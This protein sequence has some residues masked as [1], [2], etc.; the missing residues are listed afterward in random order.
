MTSVYAYSVSKTVSRR[1]NRLSYLASHKVNKTKVFIKAVYGNSEDE[2]FRFKLEKYLVS[3]LNPQYFVTQLHDQTVTYFEGLEG[4][5]QFAYLT[6]NEYFPGHL[7]LE[8]KKRAKE[9]IY[10]GEKEM[11]K[12]VKTIIYGLRDLESKRLKL[13]EITPKNILCSYEGEFKLNNSAIKIADKRS[14]SSST[15]IYLPPELKEQGG[16][17]ANGNYFLS[18]KYDVYSVGLV[19]LEIATLK[20]LQ[21]FIKGANFSEQ[22]THLLKE[23][24]NIYGVKFSRFLKEM[25]TDDINLRP[26]I[27]S[28]YRFMTSKNEYLNQESQM[29]VSEV[30]IFLYFDIL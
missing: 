28:L 20:K 17:N 10:L 29:F 14:F 23:A 1:G 4:K 2:L 19:L 5:K 16:G 9:G 18:S 6:F 11:F 22:K 8:L 7:E 13:K 3:S 12:L 24:E 30:I 27:N 26:D 15:E 21:D 25:L